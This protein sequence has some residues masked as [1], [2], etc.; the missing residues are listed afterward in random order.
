MYIICNN[1]NYMTIWR[2][3]FVAF[4]FGINNRNTV[5]FNSFQPHR[6]PD[7]ILQ[8]HHKD[9]LIKLYKFWIWVSSFCRDGRKQIDSEMHFPCSA[10][11]Q[12]RGGAAQKQCSTDQRSSQRL[13]R[14]WRNE[15]LSFPRAVSEPQRVATRWHFTTS[16]RLWWFPPQRWV[17]FDQFSFLKWSRF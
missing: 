3:S 16:R 1:N 17:F 2:L 7:S 6:Q 5:L 8:K 15:E 13:F 4:A 14:F 10:R 12:T 11:I 9:E